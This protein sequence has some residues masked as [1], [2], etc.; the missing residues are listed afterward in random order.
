MFGVMMGDLDLFVDYFQGTW[1][2]IRQAN[3]Y[4][5]RFSRVVAKHKLLM[6][7]NVRFFYIEQSYKY[8]EHNPYRKSVMV[9]I[10]NV[11]DGCS[12]LLYSFDLE[13]DDFSLEDLENINITDI[14]KCKKINDYTF[15]GSTGEEKIVKKGNRSYLFSS[16][17]ILSKNDYVVNDKGY[18]LNNGE[19]IIGSE[20]GPFKFQK[21]TK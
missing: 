10:N 21:Q 11:I 14:I 8:K 1:E 13:T 16:H 19:R 20:F 3:K 12:L 7:E 17:I 4:S 5:S 6:K 15:E 9:P 18:D 2:N